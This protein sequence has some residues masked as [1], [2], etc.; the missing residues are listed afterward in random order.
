[1]LVA[2][3]LA[4]EKKQNFQ[5]RVNKEGSKKRDE[6]NGIKKLDIFLRKEKE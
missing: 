3:E 6:N 4:I 1:M 2:R 5:R